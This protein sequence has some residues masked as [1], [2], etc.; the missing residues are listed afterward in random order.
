MAPFA[1]GHAMRWTRG[2][3]VRVRR[4]E[5]HLNGSRKTQ[6]PFDTR[7]HWHLRGEGDPLGNPG[8]VEAH[9][10]WR[11]AIGRWDEETC[12]GWDGGQV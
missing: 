3:P 4:G 8:G 11:A 5:V 6:D 7:A 2:R 1:R 9:M 10:L 12:R